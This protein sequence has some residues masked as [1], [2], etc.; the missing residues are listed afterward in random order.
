MHPGWVR[1]AA[2][3]ILGAWFS[4]VPLGLC[5]R[6]LAQPAGHGCCHRQPSSQMSAA[7]EECWLKS[8]ARTPAGPPPTA[9]A[10]PVRVAAHSSAFERIGTAPRSRPTVFSPLAI[11]L[12][13]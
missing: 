1:A 7:P 2:L 10:A 11:V 6:V 8:P 12:R 5:P 3:G 13:I 4:C 9:L